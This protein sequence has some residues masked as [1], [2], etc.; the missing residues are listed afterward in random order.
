VNDFYAP[1]A[2]V[3]V[4]GVTLA[5]DVSQELLSVSYDNNLDM[6][7]MFS[8]VLR[9]AD[10]QLTDSALFD[11]GK[12]V[13]IHMGYGDDLKPMM[14]GEIT[15]VA[16]SFP[17]GGSPTLTITGY[18]RSFRLRHDEPARKPF[19]HM[20]DS[21]IAA[22]IAAEAGLVPVVDPSPL[23]H[24]KIQ[25]TGSD[26]A[27]L[28]QRAGANF[29]ETYVFWDRLHFQFPRPQTEAYQLEW[30]K[31][32]VSFRPR[33]SSAAMAGLQVVR[34]W[35]EEL[36]QSI[37]A[38]ALSTDLD[39]G[40]IFE[41]L[42][43]TARDL[44]RSWGRRV[45]RTSIPG[46]NADATTLAKSLLTDILEGL[47]E[48][49][50]STIGIP[51]LRANRRVL[52]RGV[53]KRFSGTYRLKRVVHTLDGGG[54]RTE[55][56]V[57][58]RAGAGLLPFLRKSINELPPPNRQ[59]KFY[60]VAVG[61]VTSNTDDKQ[62]G[63]VKVSFPWF[64]DD[65]ESGWAR[66]AT[67]M[68]SKNSKGIYFLPDVDD[69]VLVAF[70]QGDISKPVVL[71]SLWNGQNRPPETNADKHNSKRH[72]LTPAGHAISL[73]DTKGSETVTIHHKSGAEVVIAHD[74]AITVTAKGKL[75]LSA[76]GDINITAKDGQGTVT[77]KAKTM[78][79]TG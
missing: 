46:S 53:G 55:F 38:F 79:V 58:Q 32:L 77:V 34:G 35:D 21:A 67:P 78:D 14:L 3:R 52:V 26:M 6:A 1:R 11:L 27:F 73:D 48:G 10:N 63:R 5:S 18:D 24:E 28:K 40:D 41:K 12:T 36:A 60:G 66:C 9:N 50:G 54:Y 49:S 2:E 43:S 76:G 29:F 17:P 59:Q 23:Y 64:G 56:E 19:Q 68:A 75:N 51:D 37:V 13:E 61:K 4:M 69:E 39:L 16:P 7:D 44:L 22:Q 33:L 70:E 45:N 71:G 25:Q 31:N 57:T 47:Y 8:V 20:T 65:H 30:G 15:A 74:G 42:G 62:R 72:I